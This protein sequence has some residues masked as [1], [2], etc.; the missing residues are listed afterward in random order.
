[1]S[2]E[3]YAKFQ[4]FDRILIERLVHHLLQP[5]RIK[6]RNEWFY[7]KNDSE[8]AYAM[9][10]IK[11]S[12]EFINNFDIKNY[13]EFKEQSKN[14]DINKELTDVK[15]LE[16]LQNKLESSNKQYYDNRRQHNIKITQ[17]RSARSG[18]FKGVSFDSQNKQWM[19]QLQYNNKQYFLGYFLDEIDGAK[20]YND[21]ALYLNQTENTKFLLNDIPGY[22]TVPRNIPQL[23]RLEKMEKKSSKYKGVSYDSRRKH[24]VA[25]IRF[26]GKTYNLGNSLDEIECAKLYNQ[27]AMYFN[28][29]FKTDYQLN[30][31]PGFITEPK[32]IY[33][34]IQDN[35]KKTSRYIGVSL[36]AAGKWACS[37]MMNRKKVH[38]GTFDTELEAC[39]EY[40][41][42]VTELNI[43]G[44]NY[45]VNKIEEEQ[46]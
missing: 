29:K 2:L 16:N 20:A 8:L 39:R 15:T 43:N 46:N 4:T 13:T 3:L 27:Q 10:T 32:D 26:T 36:T 12:L 35:K 31:I 40:N 37:Y 34:E 17:Q 11:R 19:A 24:W 33:Q 18:N 1:M 28:N 9:N 5:F 7:F 38:I 45:K 41:K 42:T 23:N 21:F 30:D 25:G 6:K 14:I 44:C 22:K